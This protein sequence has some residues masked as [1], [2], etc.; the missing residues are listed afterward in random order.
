MSKKSNRP[1]RRKFLSEATMAAAALGPGASVAA[2]SAKSIKP[3]LSAR[4]AARI[5][6]ANDRINVGMI[7]LGGMGTAHLRAFVSQSE[8]D[9]DIQIMAVCDIYTVRKERAR[10]IAKLTEKDVHHDYRDL[11]TRKDIDAVLIA[12]P[13]H[14]H[15]QIAL[16]ALTAGKDV[17][18]EKPMTHTIDEARRVVEA[19][20]KHKRILQVGV[21]GM[22]SVGAQKARE[23]IEGGEIGELLWA[24][25]TSARNSTTGEWNWR[26][27]PEG[28]P[29]NIDWKRW[30]GSAPNRPFSA[31]RYFRFRKYWDYSGGIATDLFYHSLT[32]IVYA[33]G[34]EFPISVSACGGIYVQKD[35]EVPDTYATAIEYPNFYIDLSGTMAN[36]A[37]NRQHRTAI[38]GHKGTIIFERGQIHVLPEQLGRGISRLLKP[39]P[40][41]Y[42][43]PTVGKQRISHTPHTDNFFSCVRSRK[44]PNMP[45][46]LGYRVMV[47]INLGVQ[48]YREGRSKLYDPKTQRVVNKAKPKPTWEG[49]GKN[50]PESGN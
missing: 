19:T 1:T 8:E 33:M 30:L 49:D 34:A 44:D 39:E 21:H 48:A 14:W 11:L 6:G 29:E 37:A 36:A 15:G 12:V 18:L 13:D 41:I 50:H 31:E 35:R 20:R 42:E 16:D 5:V 23:L 26:I 43:L 46:E 22:S 40:K 7:G 10:E 3:T 28:T 17:Y 32:P 47:A 2:Q 4:T 38:Y 45:A 24:Q 25:A 9:G 27:D